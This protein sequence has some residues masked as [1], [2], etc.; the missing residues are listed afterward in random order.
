MQGITKLSNESGEM[1][2]IEF[3]RPTAGHG[4]VVL[5]VAAAGICGTDIHILKGE[6]KVVPPV[7]VGHEVCGFVCDAGE[8]V[9][10]ALVGKRVVTETF[11]S[12]CHTCTYCRNGR[13]NMCANRKSIGTHANGAMTRW[14][15]VPSHGLHAV[16]DFMSDA[17]ASMA[18]PVACVTN[19]M[20]GEYNYV[21]PD[22]EVLVIGPG[23]IGLIAAQVARAAG[24]NVNIRGTT[25]DKARLDLAE[26]LG[27]SVSDNGTPL[28]AQSFDRVV[29]CS[30]S[31]YGIADALAALT[32]GG[33]LMQMGIVGRDSQLPF[34]YVCYKE[35]KVTAGFASTPK[36]WLRAM[37]LIRD[38]K[39]DLEPLV[40]D[41]CALH[42][43][44]TAFDRSMSAEGVKFVFDPRL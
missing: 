22:N 2:L 36:S 24:A 9:D 30:G 8:G 42:A 26:R 18:E 37:K 10:P 43:W 12:V 41:V 20:A 35:L 28:V 25:K 33:H 4:N 32:K 17:A 21:G 44:K 13:P 11:Y 3:P 39:V 40:S 29:E 15:E 16:P 6:Y 5:E 31:P 34:D 7:I 27:F 14:V 38:R 23:A 1:D 19:S